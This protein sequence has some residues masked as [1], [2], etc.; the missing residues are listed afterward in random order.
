MIRALLFDLD[1]TLYQERDFVLSGFR[2]VARHIEVNH[3]CSFDEAFSTM[4]AVL[5][6]QGRH[7]VLPRLISQHL[8]SSVPVSGLVEVYRRHAPEISLFP[9]YADLLVKFRDD[10]KLGIITDGLPLVQRK[11][12]QALGLEPIMDQIIYTWELGA[13][14]EKPHPLSFSLM[15]RCFNVDPSNALFIGDNPEKDCRGA[16][17]AGMKCVQIKGTARDG[18]SQVGGTNCR[19]EF[20][21]ESLFQL[22]GI[23]ESLD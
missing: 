5:D 10:F 15:V 12:V 23:L 2:A 3:G 16:H 1:D 22:P 7:E 9:G 14:N 6:T 20:A 8:D 4:V 19:P 11:K 17:A 13:Q 21:V 18:R